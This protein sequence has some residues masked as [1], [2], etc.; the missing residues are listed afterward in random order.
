[1][2]EVLFL[3]RRP[4]EVMP[5]R[6]YYYSDAGSRLTDP[7]FLTAILYSVPAIVGA[8]AEP[9]DAVTILDW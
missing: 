6:S 9:F 2:E 1:M 5:A 7:I 4:F 8:F 3:I